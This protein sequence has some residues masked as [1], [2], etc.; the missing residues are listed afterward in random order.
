MQA[1]V[2]AM[3]LS[4]AGA[5][6][7]EVTADLRREYLAGDKL[8]VPITLANTSG[9][10]ATVLQWAASVAASL[11]HCLRNAPRHM[12]GRGTAAIRI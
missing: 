11:C 7:L 6:P 10:T 8:L 4:V 2:L 5:E 12:K 3:V 1:V 9:E